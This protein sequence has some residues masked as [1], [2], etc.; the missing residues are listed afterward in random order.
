VKCTQCGAA[1]R[2]ADLDVRGRTATCRFCGAVTELPPEPVSEPL[3]PAAQPENTIVRP[4]VPRPNS[5]VLDQTASG[6]RLTYRWFNPMLIFLACFCIAW[7][8]F[9]VAWYSMGLGGFFNGAPGPMAWLFFLFPIGHVAV[10][11]ALTYYTLAGFVNRTLIDVSH[12]ELQ[13]WNGPVP[14]K[15]NKTLSAADVDTIYSTLNVGRSRNNQN[16][17]CVSAL[18][19]DGRTAT[20]ISSLPSAQE[21]RYIERTIEEFLG[22]Q[23]H[24]V[25]GEL[26]H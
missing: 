25:A 4:K 14:W 2:D 17:F 3:P 9:L 22:L 15:G 6:I 10:G 13:V 5:I 19:K 26:P 18:L 21:A 8:G 23:H 20:I 1:F 11:V 24:H 12:D 16:L 7:D